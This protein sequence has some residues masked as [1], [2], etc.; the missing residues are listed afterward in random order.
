MKTLQETREFLKRLRNDYGEVLGIVGKMRGEIETPHPMKLEF[1][2]PTQ[3]IRQSPR[4]S[5]SPSPSRSTF[6]PP[7]TIKEGKPINIAA[8]ID[9]MRCRAEIE[10]V[11]EPENFFKG[12]FDR[13]SRGFL[14]I[15]ENYKKDIRNNFTRPETIDGDTSLDFA[16]RLASVIQKRFH[17]ILK[18]CRTGR[19]TVDANIRTYYRSIE[20][21]VM[22]Y[23]KRIGLKEFALSIGDDFAKADHHMKPMATSPAPSAQLDNKIAEIIVLPYYIEYHGNDGEIEKYWIDGQCIVYKQK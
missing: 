15:I 14:E 16:E 17:T 21:C 7:P 18:S 23:F 10:N 19:K 8:P 20:Q 1:I 9:W 6:Q 12:R 13:Q 22:Q 4:P 11:S 5:P 2:P 3:P